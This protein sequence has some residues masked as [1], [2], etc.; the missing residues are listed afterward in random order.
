MQNL[1]LWLWRWGPVVLLMLVIFIAS[2]TPG[3][4]L[5]EFGVW[6]FFAKKGGHLTGYALLAAAWSWGLDQGMGSRRKIL[7]L[8]IA[9]SWLYAC[10]DEFHQ[11]FVPGRKAL[12][13]DVGIDTIGAALGSTLW[14]WI[15]S[16]KIIRGV[17]R[18]ARR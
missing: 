5:P 12:L 3:N 7:L 4:D 10:S 8:S 6:D 16:S 18:T 13:S 1:K 11:I 2:G 15:K 17:S 9:F 14:P